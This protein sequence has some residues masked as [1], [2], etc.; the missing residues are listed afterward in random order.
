MLNQELLSNVIGNSF[1]M[2]D[3]LLVQIAALIA[4]KNPNY[5]TVWDAANRICDRHLPQLNRG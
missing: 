5:E 3:L 1:P 2:C 4:L